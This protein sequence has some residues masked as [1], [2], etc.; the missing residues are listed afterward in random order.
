MEERN[1]GQTI[2]LQ[3]FKPDEQ[4]Q[5]LLQRARDDF[6]ELRQDLMN[7]EQLISRQQLLRRL[8]KMCP[9]N[10]EDTR[11]ERSLEDL[12]FAIIEAVESLPYICLA[13]GG[14]VGQK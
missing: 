5:K 13:S 10:W 6:E 1:N 9:D 14:D 8:E 4:L 3:D 12:Y 11:E 7:G 2:K